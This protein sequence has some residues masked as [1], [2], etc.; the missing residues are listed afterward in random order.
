MRST[1]AA[2]LTTGSLLLGLAAAGP[3]SAVRSHPPDRLVC[4]KGDNGGTLV[5]GVC[6]L[7]G[8]RVGQAYEGF[9]ITSRSSGGTFLIVSGSIPPGLSMPARYG[10]SGTIVA[11]TPTH[12]GSFSFT[13]K[14]TDQEGQR[15]RQA[16]RI[17]VGHP[18]PLTDT[19]INPLPPGTVGAVYA[20]NF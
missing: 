13:V 17:S 20:A 2:A 12:E 4:S 9:I 18:L 5:N 15:L 7:P 8:A 10:A 16:Y 19:T 6:V 14:G 11:G 1:I 3:A